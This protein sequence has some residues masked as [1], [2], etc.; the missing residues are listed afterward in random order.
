M[1]T[2]PERKR[3]PAVTT[4]RKV[5]TVAVT[6]LLILVVVFGVEVLLAVPG[7]DDHFHNPGRLPVRFGHGGRPLTYVV[8]G[9]S[10]AAGRGAPYADGIA[11]R[12]ARSLAR[13]RTVILV[14]LAV[15]GARVAD[16][17]RDQ[18]PE[19]ARL[20]PDLV[21]LAV[22]ANDATHFTPG[23]ALGSGLAAILAGLA[24][25]R[26]SVRVVQTG[27]PDVGTVPRFAQPLRW[28]AGVQTSRVNRIL[29]TVGREH[30]AVWAPIARETGPQFARDHSL[31]APDRFHPNGRGYAT[32]LPVLEAA[33]D[34]ALREHAAGVHAAGGLGL[35]SIT[36]LR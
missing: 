11:V 29:A 13:G 23:R 15:S 25:A 5:V 22:G 10:T 35:I 28:L 19:A 17:A 12:T 6:S 7:P 20:R 33:L 4:T 16:V 14:N 27:S 21:L 24:A 18:L 3:S 8:M 2:R 32:W 26:P 30:G 9:D 36:K 34:E 31:F 1:N